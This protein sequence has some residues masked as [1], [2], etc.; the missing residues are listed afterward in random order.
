MTSGS[1]IQSMRNESFGLGSR[2]S[3]WLKS[4]P[5]RSH[6]PSNERCRNGTT[7]TRS[8]APATS[9]AIWRHPKW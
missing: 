6:E 8:A 5:G 2:V 4:P 1:P 3:D 9:E 7:E